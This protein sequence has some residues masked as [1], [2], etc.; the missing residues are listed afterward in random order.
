MEH[1]DRQ[2]MKLIAERNA[3][4][5]A[6]LYDRYAP[7]MFGLVVKIVGRK[8]WAE[9]VMQEAFWKIWQTA[10][11]YD[12]DRSSPSVWILMILRSKAI[13]RLRKESRRPSTTEL[14]QHDEVSTSKQIKEATEDGGAARFRDVF[15][16]LPSEQREAITLSFYRGLSHSEIAELLDCPVGTVK[17]RIYLGMQKLKRAAEVRRGVAAESD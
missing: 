11:R 14:E 17:T 3:D 8:P 12:P 13:D 15:T 7:R 4:A 1:D 10:D 2:L 5:F 9:D 6:E 16:D